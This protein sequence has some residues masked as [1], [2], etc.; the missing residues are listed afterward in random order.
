MDFKKVFSPSMIAATVLLFV[1]L[2]GLQSVVHAFE[3]FLMKE[4]VPLRRRLYLIPEHVGPYQKVAEETLSK[5]VVDE[6]GTDQYISWTYTN[7]QLKPDEPGARIRLHIAYYT[8]TPDAIPHV[9]ERCYVGGGATPKDSTQDTLT[10]DSPAIYSV[11]NDELMATDSMGRTV[12]LPGREIPIRLFDFVPHNAKEPA[13]VMYFF[14]ANGK[15]I[16]VPRDVRNLVFD[17]SSRYAYWCKI[18]LLPF[19]VKDHEE[20]KRIGAAFLSQMM[21]EI[22]GCLPDWTEVRAGRYPVEKTNK[23]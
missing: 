13:T 12:H 3:I 20:A 10:L 2:V 14:A 21:P 22:M 1:G 17:L 15:L 9:P 4:P 16:A 5:E 23:R 11:A 8:G 6:L 7:T 19:G 18:E